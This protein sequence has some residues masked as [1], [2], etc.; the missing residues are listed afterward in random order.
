[1]Y[2]LSCGCCGEYFFLPEPNKEWYYC[3]TCGNEVK[4]KNKYK[5]DIPRKPTSLNLTEYKSLG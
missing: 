2:R 1:M 4:T 3:P 5:N